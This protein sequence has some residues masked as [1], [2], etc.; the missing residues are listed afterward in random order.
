[1]KFVW[2]NDGH[3]A[4][5]NKKRLKDSRISIAESLTACRIRQLNKAQ[6]ENGFRNV[7]SHDGKILFTGNG[8]NSTKLFY[9]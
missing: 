7:Q 3:K 9:G 5:S 6:D 8:S 1:M 4:Y 2:Y